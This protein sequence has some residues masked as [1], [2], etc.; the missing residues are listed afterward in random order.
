MVMR[1][2]TRTASTVLVSFAISILLVAPALTLSDRTLA[3]ELTL[4]PGMTGVA[5]LGAT[6]CETF[7]QMHPAGPTGME[8]AVLTWAQGY[9]YAQSG[10]TTNEIL[11]ALPDGGAEWKFDTLTGHIVAYCAARPEAAIPDAVADLWAQLRPPANN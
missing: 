8:Q 4:R 1:S 3:A 5:D 6:S 2:A 9:F 7:N 11:A 10:K